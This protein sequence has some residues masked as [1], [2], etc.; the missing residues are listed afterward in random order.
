MLSFSLSL[1]L[2]Y[3]FLP[4]GLNWYEKK[5][6]K[7]YDGEDDYHIPDVSFGPMNLTDI[8]SNIRNSFTIRKKQT[9]YQIKKRKELKEK[10]THIFIHDPFLMFSR[11]MINESNRNR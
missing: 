7:I 8:H 1:S 6:H 4:E 5:K 10:K 2:L 9:K 3:W 11:K